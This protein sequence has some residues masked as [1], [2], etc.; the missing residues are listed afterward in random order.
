MDDGWGID[1][2]KYGPRKRISVQWVR[3]LKSLSIH[4]FGFD[5]ETESI[6]RVRKTRNSDSGD[7]IGEIFRKEDES[8]PESKRFTLDR[9]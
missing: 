8:M 2:E 4:M 5:Y 3:Y 1:R 6:S 9:P 7:V